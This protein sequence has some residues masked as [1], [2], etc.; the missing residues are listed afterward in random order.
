MIIRA[1]ICQISASAKQLVLP[2]IYCK[3][4][5]LLQRHD[6][7]NRNFLTWETVNLYVSV[8]SLMPLLFLFIFFFIWYNRNTFWSQ[9]IW[10]PHDVTNTTH[11]SW[12]TFFVAEVDI[13]FR[14]AGECLIFFR[15]CCMLTS[16]GMLGKTFKD[17]SCAC[18]E[19]AASS[20]VVWY[21]WGLGCWTPQGYWCRDCK[22]WLTDWGMCMTLHML[23]WKIKSN[24]S[25]TKSALWKVG[26]VAHLHDGASIS[27]PSFL[28]CSFL[29]LFSYSL[30]SSLLLLLHSS[31]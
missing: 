15:E 19:I 1:K 4:A 14:L 30:S 3:E 7:P 11:R 25:P 13:N 21:L 12:S 26:Y 16:S 17:L 9:S 18:S 2:L 8:D 6:L 24:H 22:W 20:T 31:P 5:L 10:W 23:C 28:Y 27:L 29:T